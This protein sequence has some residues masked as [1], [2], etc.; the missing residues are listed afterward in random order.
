[1]KRKKKLSIKKLLSKSIGVLCKLVVCV[2]F[3]FPFYWMLSTSFKPF[4][5]TLKFPPTLWPETFTLSGYKAVFTEVNLWPYIKNTII[6]TLSCMV[7]SLVINVM[8]AYAFAKKD[9][10]GKQVAWII[11]MMTVMVPGQ[12]TFMT[13]YFMMGDWG[14]LNTLLPQ[15][16][17]CCAGAFTIFLLRQNFMQIPEEIIEAARMDNASEWKIL[18]KLMLPMVKPILV[19]TLISSFNGH[20]NAY[21]WPLMMTRTEELKPITLAIERLRS[22]EQ[23]FNYTNIMAGS[24][25]LILPTVIIYLLF[26]KKIVK[27]S[28]Y[29]GVK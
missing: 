2:I 23:G 17:P 27:T 1:M 13:V 20:W 26:G 15:I 4:L 11:T 25:I 18:W 24:V 21:F 6:I 9:F 12:L 10:K 16:L 5:E 19:L 22:V 28:G 8:A 7:I 3:L 14:L 29:R